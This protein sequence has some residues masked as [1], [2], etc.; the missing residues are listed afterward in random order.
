M[1]SWRKGIAQW[2][3]KDRLYL[4]IVFT[5]QLPEARDIAINS[6]KKVIVGGPAVKLMPG[7]L[8]DIAKVWSIWLGRYIRAALFCG[9]EILT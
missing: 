4:S 8:A 5:W 9:A 7:Y 6:R 2:T 1:Y 3:V